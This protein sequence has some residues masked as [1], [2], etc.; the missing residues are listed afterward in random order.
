[1]NN[2]IDADKLGILRQIGY[3]WDAV[4]TQWNRWVVGFSQ[5]RQ[6]DFLGGLGMREVDWRSMAI[7]LIVAVLSTGGVAGLFLY[8]RAVQTR[9]EPLV[10][11]YERLCRKLAKAGIERAPHEGPLNF[12]RRLQVFQP[13]IAQKAAPLFETYITLRYA[14]QSETQAGSVGNFIARVRRFRAE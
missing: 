11:A 9:K 1:M 3:S 12:W 5:D 10:A 14:M 13:D 6:K 7:W 2:L 4:N 8:V